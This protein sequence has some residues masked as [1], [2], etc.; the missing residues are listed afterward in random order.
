MNSCKISSYSIPADWI[1]GAANS[2][3]W[4]LA[5][6]CQG[7]E[8]DTVCW[9]Q[10]IYMLHSSLSC[11]MMSCGSRTA[12]QAQ[13]CTLSAWWVL[14]LCTPHTTLCTRHSN[15]HSVHGGCYTYVHHTQHCVQDTAMYI[16]CMMGVTLLY[17]IHTHTTLRTRHNSVHS[18]H[19][20][21]Y[22][23]VHHT[24]NTTYKTQQC[25]LSA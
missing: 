13:H 12:H 3:L 2:L 5:N 20:G 19:D 6:F 21:C 16:Q 8:S 15:V 11:V 22:T 24:H 14:H 23:S 7:S 17:T 18:V 4:R 25:T 9:L 1:L 10:T